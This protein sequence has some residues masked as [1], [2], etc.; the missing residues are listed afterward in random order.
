MRKPFTELP[1]LLKTV[2]GWPSVA[3]LRERT[4]LM[5]AEFAS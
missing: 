4:L 3:Q 5:G 2:V 1:E